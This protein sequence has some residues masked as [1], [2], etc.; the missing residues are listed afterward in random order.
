MTPASTHLKKSRIRPTLAGLALLTAAVTFLPGRVRAQS[1]S[2]TEY[3]A[4]AALLFNIA[5]YADW[6]AAAFSRPDSPIVIGVLGDD[7]FG[8]VLDRV[9]RGRL[10]NGRPFVV[11]R[12]GGIADLK[13]AHLVFVSPS[14]S[15]AAQDC[16]ML[17]GFN[18]LTVGDTGQTALFTAFNFAVE[19]ERIV[20]SVDLGRAARA[21]VTLSSKLLNLAKAVKRTSDT[22]TR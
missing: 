18:V 3:S 22:D 12:A 5:K 6:P 21:G 14:E 1:V 4:K 8:E 13:G 9:V 17:E 15:H 20:F 2:L 16:A 19:G 11:R 7:P 10:V